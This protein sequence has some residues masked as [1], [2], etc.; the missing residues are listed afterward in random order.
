MVAEDQVQQWILVFLERTSHRLLVAAM[1]LC[2]A[3]EP[4]LAQDCNLDQE[5]RKSGQSVDQILDQEPMTLLDKCPKP[6][7]K[8]APL[9]PI[10]D[11]QST[12]S[13]V[14]RDDGA[15]AV[16]AEIK[17]PAS[18]LSLSLSIW[19]NT[20]TSLRTEVLLEVAT[21][22]TAQDKLRDING[23]ALGEAGRSVVEKVDIASAPIIRGAAMAA[24]MGSDTRQEEVISALT[25][26]KFL[27]LDLRLDSS[28]MRVRVP[29][30]D[31]AQSLLAALFR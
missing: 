15:D 31:Q 6:A 21:A 1:V 11:A 8:A 29:L 3:V 23:L 17:V 25:A 14:K 24:V 22:L 20:D 9:V 2:L 26:A 28:T 7:A 27:D 12:W 13:L 30:D 16:Q 19:R 4:S 5:L 10:I 18:D